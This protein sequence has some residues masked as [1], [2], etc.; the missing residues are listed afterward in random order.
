LID[1]KEEVVVVR[2]MKS[3]MMSFFFLSSLSPS[4]SLPEKRVRVRASM[5]ERRSNSNESNSRFSV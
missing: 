2:D 1:D 3:W 4:L 5:R